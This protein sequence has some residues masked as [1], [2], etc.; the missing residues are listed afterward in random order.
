MRVRERSD[1][2]RVRIQEGADKVFRN[3]TFIVVVAVAAMADVALDVQGLWA[4]F[5]A[6][7]DERPHGLFRHIAVARQQRAR[8]ATGPRGSSGVRLPA[9]STRRR[10]VPAATSSAAPRSRPKPAS[11]PSSSSSSPDVRHAEREARRARSALDL[12]VRAERSRTAA[13]AVASTRPPEL[14]AIH[15]VPD[16]SLLPKRQILTLMRTPPPSPPLSVASADTIAL[17]PATTVSTPIPT[18]ASRTPS[19]VAPPPA[20]STVTFRVTPLNP[21]LAPSPAP[22]PPSLARRLAPVF[23]SMRHLLDAT[24]A[25][26]SLADEARRA[27]EPE[28]PAPA[29][30]PLFTMVVP[31]PPTP[32]P[33][34]APAVSSARLVSDDE[35]LDSVLALLAERAPT[36]RPEA[37]PTP[38]A[39]GFL[40]L[41]TQSIAD[42]VLWTM[43]QGL[44]PSVDAALRDAARDAADDRERTHR[45][46]LHLAH[47]LETVDGRAA[48]AAVHAQRADDAARTTQSHV[49]DALAHLQ[50]VHAAV[51]EQHATLRRIDDTLRTLDERVTVVGATTDA[52]RRD[53]LSREDLVTLRAHIEDDVRRLLASL[54]TPAP[55]QINLRVHVEPAPPAPAGIPVAPPRPALVAPPHTDDNEEAEAEAEE[56]EDVNEESD[57]EEDD[58]DDDAWRQSAMQAA[59]LTAAWRSATS[60][61]SGT[62]VPARAVD[63]THGEDGS[64]LSSTSSSTTSSSSSSSDSSW[65]SGAWSRVSRL[66]PLRQSV[67]LMSPTSGGEPLWG[68]MDLS[69]GEVQV[70]LEETASVGEVRVVPTDHLVFPRV[71][72]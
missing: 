20:T 41:D 37:A 27:P 18:V 57:E 33:P 24:R 14:C 53:A 64:T 26:H 36:P 5:S 25:A 42:T 70:D 66:D 31:A 52:L 9:D 59:R 51:R 46:L 12:L 16:T 32:P 56:E 7:I 50:R 71:H 43:R 45:V 38:A 60:G 35:I 1:G 34:A 4:D 29:Q 62:R 8:F 48:Q 28:P 49:D 68:T 44:V 19:F 6:A 23:E 13:V 67:S 21:S 2:P 39:H 47:A 69:E 72:R 54:P 3:D 11:A 40:G 63:E 65:D 61:P 58:G 55:P 15:T 10:A 17:T 30:P 22:S